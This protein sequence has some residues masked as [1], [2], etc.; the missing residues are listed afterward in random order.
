MQVNGPGILNFS[1][2]NSPTSSASVSGSA[3]S[4]GPYLMRWI[5]T[6]GA[7]SNSDTVQIIFDQPVI[8]SDAGQD[9][10]VCD[11]QLP[12]LGAIDPSVG[13]G[14]WK[15]VFGSGSLTFSDS[16]FHNS[17]VSTS[18]YGLYQASWT[19]TN[20]S[21]SS[22]DTISLIFKEP[23]TLA[24]AGRDQQLCGLATTLAGNNA[25]TG[26]GHWS[27]ASGPG[28]LTFVNVTAPN[29]I[30]TASDYGTY[31]IKWTI[32]N[33]N[34]IRED[35]LVVIFDENPTQAQAGNDVLICN[36]N[37]YKLNA[38]A[39]V[40]GNGRWTII[41]GSANFSNPDLNTAL[42]MELQT[43]K[44]EFLW[45]SS[46]GVCPTS[47]DTLGV[48]VSVVKADFNSSKSTCAAD[49]MISLTDISTPAP[50]KWS[51]TFNDGNSSF[52][53]HPKHAYADTG[54]FSIK[55]VVENSYACI[56]SM[57]KNI[58]IYNVLDLYIPNSF[59]PGG[60]GKND[61]FKVYGEGIAEVEMLIFNRWG[62]LIFQAKDISNGWNGRKNNTGDKAPPGVYIYKLKVIDYY[63]NQKNTNGIINLLR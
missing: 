2:P 18:T 24:E 26:Q 42:A 22:S 34:C 45:I 43:G 54:A 27:K 52:L 61:E 31:I 16:N 51:W 35:T 19:V 20:G 28:T 23:A 3:L 49:E 25:V 62:E 47:E 40:V 4:Y 55:L 32:S 60:N 5:L 63:G 10:E 30:V 56:D 9:F 50:I 57:E 1:N 39:P 59:T 41:N 44:N 37:E 33:L 17:A 7:Y 46:N 48:T 14:F 15:Q 36:V 12:L 6:N 21:C 13:T 8:P 58:Y 29:S 53:R 38:V 11:D